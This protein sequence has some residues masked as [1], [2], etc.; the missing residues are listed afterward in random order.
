M[1]TLATLRVCASLAMLCAAWLG[2]RVAVGAGLRNRGAIL[3]ALDAAP[4]LLAWI[5]LCCVLRRPVLAGVIL[6]A[7]SL[8]LACG[9]AAKRRSSN[10]PL[11][12]SDKGQAS[13]FF[14]PALYAEVVHSGW[15][16]AGAVIAA[17]LLLVAGYAEPP[18]LTTRLPA[19]LC[20][21]AV[22]AAWLNRPSC[23]R[24][25]AWAG[26][27]AEACPKADPA[28]CARHMGLA[29]S[30]IVQA[31]VAAAERQER[32][33]PHAPCRSPALPF[34]HDFAGPIVMVQLESFFDARRSWAGLPADLLPEFDRCVSASALHGR[35]ATPAWGANTV[36]TEF[37]ALTGL[38]GEVLGL[39]RFNPYAAFARVPVDSIAWRLR[40][41][42]F[43]TVC[44][45]PFDRRFYGRDRV[46]PHLGFD[47][48]LDIGDF[49]PPSAGQRYV[50]DSAVVAKIE[51]LLAERGPR[52]FIFA[53]T[54]GN[55]SPWQRLAP[56][57]AAGDTGDAAL[58]GYL[59]G[60]RLTDAALG[61]LAGTLRSHW[62]DS[63]LA[64]FGDHQPSLS[65]RYGGGDDASDYVVMRAGLG[66]PRRSDLAAHDLPGMVMR[67][68]DRE[69]FDAPAA[70][71]DVFVAAPAAK[72]RRP[73]FLKK[74]S[75]KLL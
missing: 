8:C 69:R 27:A 23:H 62:P 36:R 4:F 29:G 53:I 25:K 41:A 64:A 51:A 37:A 30:V 56:P 5:W 17:G 19:L 11:V 48:F 57:A 49:P 2:L 52:V 35:L 47:M 45:H 31:A 72:V 34:A 22:I 9:S 16:A 1:L 7:M 63:V 32:R 75:K 10:E 12:F 50:P 68:A 42:G 60:L 39:D 28:A 59:Q 65:R 6:C 70:N 38:S 58:A 55:H 40:A 61:R 13:I 26:A 74:R 71:D 15:L 18:V 46:L 24:L 66:A 33:R 14:Y 43:R 44:I 20:T 73:A 54:M 3:L 21:V 67:L